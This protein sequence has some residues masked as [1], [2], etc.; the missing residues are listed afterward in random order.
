MVGSPDERYKCE[1]TNL[2]M[3]THPN[4]VLMAKSTNI[5]PH[6]LAKSQKIVSFMLR[7]FMRF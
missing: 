2:K 1:C 3:N 4:L 6:I 7:E 5:Q